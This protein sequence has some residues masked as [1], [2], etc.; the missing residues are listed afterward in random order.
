MRVLPI[1]WMLITLVA[2]VIMVIRFISKPVSRTIARRFRKS[3]TKT[4]RVFNYVISLI[5]LVIIGISVWHYNLEITA[6]ISS[7]IFFLTA[8]TAKL[9][10]ESSAVYTL[11][12]AGKSENLDSILLILVFLAVF[13]LIFSLLYFF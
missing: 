5:L 1:V 6:V 3:R 12:P 4:E 10:L 9:L 8:A 11:Y 2:A 13:V 7:G